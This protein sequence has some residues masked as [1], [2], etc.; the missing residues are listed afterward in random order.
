M[1][2][3]VDLQSVTS[4]RNSR[5]CKIFPDWSKELLDKRAVLLEKADITDLITENFGGIW[6]GLWKK[7]IIV[8]NDV[9]F[10]E[11][12]GYEDNYWM[13]LMR[14]YLEKVSFVNQVG[15]VYRLSVVSTMRAKNAEHHYERITVERMLHDELKGRKLW[16]K[17]IEAWEWLF[18]SRYCFNTYFHFLERFDNPD[19]KFL[20][21][22][23]KDLS[24]AFP[25]W[26]SNRYLKHYTSKK[27]RLLCNIIMIAPCSMANVLK[28]KNK[29]VSKK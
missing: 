15:Y 1:P 17:H 13:S 25:K 26:R 8:D 6:C 3:E 20:K 5:K 12:L 10:P 14:C 7:S 19:M 29:I 9:W 28:Q 18:V 24:K 21:G 4:Y 23:L 27:Y 16:D 2:N 22:L 11:K